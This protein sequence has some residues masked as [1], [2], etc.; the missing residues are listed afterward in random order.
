MNTAPGL[1][2]SENNTKYTRMTPVLGLSG[3]ITN[4]NKLVITLFICSQSAVLIGLH[5]SLLISTDC[6]VGVGS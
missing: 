4:Y 5:K 3:A 2:R 1:G 6:S